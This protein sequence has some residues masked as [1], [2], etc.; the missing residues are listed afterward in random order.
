MD[1]SSGRH[2]TNNETADFVVYD[3]QCDSVS[4]SG[5]CWL[6]GHPSEFPSPLK[7]DAFECEFLCGW[8]V[9]H[10]IRERLRQV[11]KEEER[12]DAE[13]HGY[14]ADDENEDDV[15]DTADTVVSVT[16]DEDGHIEGEMDGLPS[17]ATPRMIAD[18]H[19]REHHPAASQDTSI[20]SYHFGADGAAAGSSYDTGDVDV[21]EEMH[22][23]LF[24]S[25]AP[26]PP[27]PPTKPRDITDKAARPDDLQ[28]ASSGKRKSK[29]SHE[30]SKD[31]PAKKQ[32]I[33]GG[34]STTVSKDP[35]NYFRLGGR[36]NLLGNKTKP[37]SGNDIF[38]YH[39]DER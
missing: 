16:I 20:T 26:W 21:Y 29:D 32:K 30:G 11:K 14:E 37:S 31:R 9:P 7:R 19:N 24:P 23:T 1:I 33:V 18:D 15:Q 22:K 5:P 8:P 25:G 35:N 6:C 13:L 17:Q 36:H 38:G 27:I 10:D 28:I 4:S 3:D 34:P 39:G 2:D 12:R